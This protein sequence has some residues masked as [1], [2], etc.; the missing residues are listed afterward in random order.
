VSD[1]LCDRVAIL[2]NGV[3]VNVSAVAYQV[4][5][6]I[7]LHG[8]QLH[9]LRLLRL[10]RSEELSH[11]NIQL[12]LVVHLVIQRIQRAQELLLV[13]IGQLDLR[14]RCSLLPRLLLRG[15]Q[16]LDVPHKL[17]LWGLLGLLL[18][19]LLSCLCGL[20]CGLLGSLLLVGLLG[21]GRPLRLGRR[22]D[23][24]LLDLRNHRRGNRNHGLLLDRLLLCLEAGHLRRLL[25]VET[26]CNLIAHAIQEAIVQVNPQ[27]AP[28][29]V[30]QRDVPVLRVELVHEERC[31]LLQIEC[32]DGLEVV[33]LAE[34]AVEAVDDDGRHFARLPSLLLLRPYPF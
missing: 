25:D 17:R 18:C 1:L 31:E 14:I 34:C 15:I 4:L 13:I 2:Q 12:L 20:L 23:L 21:L 5:L 29:V 10:L 11:V 24:H 7:E 30:L 16:L 9:I 8:R 3:L 22:L 6:A 26:L 28:R 32:L 27:A 33:D 19:R